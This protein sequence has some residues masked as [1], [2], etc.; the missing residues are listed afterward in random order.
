[1]KSPLR[2]YLFPLIL[3]T[4]LLT[5][6][7]QSTKETEADMRERIE[8]ELDTVEKVTVMST[9]GQEVML[10]LPVF[11]KELSEQEKDLQISSE[12]LKQEDVRFTLVL[13]RRQLAPLVVSVGEKASQ[14]GESTYRG[15][16]ATFF[17]QWIHRQTGKGLLSQQIEGV[18]LF[19]EDL[20]QDKV[21]G[22]AESA[23]M[24]KVLDT[25]VP[26]TDLI[27]NQYPLHPYYRLQLDSTE[28]PLEVTVL[29]PTLIS[30]PFGRDT[31]VFHVEG[32]MFSQLTKWLPPADAEEQSVERL[33]K[34]TQIQLK[35]SGGHP[36]PSIDLNVTE[37]TV[38]QGIGHQVVRLLKSGM[39]I[40]EPPLKQGVEQYRLH[41]Q[42]N[43]GVQTV[44]FYD[45]YY[46]VGKNWF[47]H[48][49][50]DQKVLKLLEPPKK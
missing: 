34:A 6:C 9:D 50:L 40:E 10:D 13:Y 3:V 31:H 22:E 46:Q 15:N 44:V 20:S 35:S 25:A 47:T 16:G 39:P 7:S 48:S 27:Q 2:T 30:V 12:S 21:L 1:M 26:V 11:L 42:M 19:A 24:K 17:Y 36:F 4:A 38:E 14:F 33:Y 5:G 29:T 41:F 18:R 28:R 49:G 45:R 32:P 37:T 43:D 8:T 23:Y